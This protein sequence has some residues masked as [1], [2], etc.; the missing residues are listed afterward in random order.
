MIAREGSG[1]GEMHWGAE[2]QA[3]FRESPRC[4]IPA[5]GRASPGRSHSAKPT[6]SPGEEG[7]GRAGGGRS[8]TVPW[9]LLQAA[10]PPAGGRR[11]AEMPAGGPAAGARG[12]GIW[13]SAAGQ[14]S[15]RPSLCGEDHPAETG[16]SGAW[17]PREQVAPHSSPFSCQDPPQLPVHSVTTSLPRVT[18]AACKIWSPQR[19]PT[20]GPALRWV[21]HS[22]VPSQR[23]W[24]SLP[25]VCWGE[26]PQVELGV[27]TCLPCLPRRALSTPGLGGQACSL[28]PELARGL[29][30]RVTHG[31]EKPRLPR[32]IQW[33]WLQD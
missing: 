1:P 7:F 6:R 24:T 28:A 25:S 13:E 8:S 2:S 19:I 32:K 18:F 30:E 4:S 29:S 16:G 11:D 20:C 31:T 9:L 23:R 27:C 15:A 33:F 5:G 21:E 22:W 17:R 10:P 12:G 14:R 26:F 3:D